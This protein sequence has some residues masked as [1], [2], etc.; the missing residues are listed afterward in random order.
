[1]TYYETIT[2]I[3]SS[4]Y[5]KVQAVYLFGSH[6]TEFEQE[7]SDVDI[8]ILLPPAESKTTDHNTMEACSSRLALQL[9]K[10]ID[11]INLRC[12]DTVFQCRILETGRLIFS[13]DTSAR[14]LFEM[15][16]ISAYQKLQEERKGILEAILK[17]GRILA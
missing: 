6:G 17:S 4:Y 13:G 2:Q 3:I 14:Q 16:A 12:V 8:A 5:P 9:C 11:L 10:S 1:M 15:T 7:Q